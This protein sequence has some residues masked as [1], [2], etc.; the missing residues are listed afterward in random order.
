M[1]LRVL[2]IGGAYPVDVEPSFSVQFILKV[3]HHAIGPMFA[4]A[5]PQMAA[6]TLAMR[7][8]TSQ[9]MEEDYIRFAQARG[10]RDSVIA[11]KYIKTMR[12]Y[13]WLP[14]LQFR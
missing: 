1:R 13:R 6:W 14:T 7:G 10:L 11:N 4:T 5:I 2:P 12:C 9:V 3:L 8:N